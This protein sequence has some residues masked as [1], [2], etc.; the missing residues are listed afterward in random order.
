VPELAGTI[1]MGSVAAAIALAG[2]LEEGIA[3]ALWCVVAARSVAAVPYVRTQV[4]RTRSNPPPTWPSDLA[5]MCA[6]AFAAAGATFGSVPGAAVVTIVLVALLNIVL[7]R[8]PPKP[9]VQIGIQQ[10]IVGIV[11]VVT[12]AVALS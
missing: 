9:A 2:G 3:L 10:V 11:V 5:Q 12:T 8:R 1:G 6:V 7:V 4:L